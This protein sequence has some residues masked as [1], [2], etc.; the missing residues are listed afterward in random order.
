MQLLVEMGFNQDQ[1]SV[2]L[3][4]PTGGEREP[5]HEVSE[6]QVQLLVEMGFNQDQVRH[7]LQLHNNDISMATNF[8]LQ[9]T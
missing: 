2:V 9:Q 8:L 5:V 3:S 7:A 1:L 6:D 4:L